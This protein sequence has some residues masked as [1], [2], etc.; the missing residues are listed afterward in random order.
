M[1]QNQ[2]KVHKDVKN[3]F[4]KEKAS[5]QDVELVVEPVAELAEH[6][7]I[8]TSSGGVNNV[9]P[10]TDRR[11]ETLVTLQHDLTQQGWRSCTVGPCVMTLHQE[12]RLVGIFN[13]HVDGQ[14]L[15]GD[16][17]DPS[18]YTYLIRH[19]PATKG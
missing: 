6:L 19:C 9:L 7:H 8:S 10:R 13:Y 4:L 17:S 16:E 2:F 11:S 15:A 18:T 1:T 3:A 14:M 5:G 12:S